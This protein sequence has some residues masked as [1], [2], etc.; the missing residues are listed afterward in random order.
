V[1]S[2]THHGALDFQERFTTSLKHF[3]FSQNIVQGELNL[4]VIML[5]E[6][7]KTMPIWQVSQIIIINM[8]SRPIFGENSSLSPAW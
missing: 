6:L 3:D 7:A 8:L 1:Y 2:T 5:G 4:S